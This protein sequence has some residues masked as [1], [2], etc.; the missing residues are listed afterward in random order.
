MRH[1]IVIAALLVLGCGDTSGGLDASE[2][3]TDGGIGPV[4]DAATGIDGGASDDAGRPPD[5]ATMADA[6]TVATSDPSGPGPYEVMRSTASLGDSSVA[7]FDPALPSGE[8]GPLVVFLH[9]FQLS[10]ANYVTTLERIATHGYV[11]VGLDSG[12][13]I[14][15]GP[16]QAEQAAQMSAAIDWALGAPVADRVDADRIAVMGHSRGGKVAVMVAAQDARVG[17]LLALDPV[18]SCGP[19]TPYSADC[20][21]VTTG[22]W[23]P[24]LAMPV[25]YMGETLDGSGGFMPCAPEAQSYATIYDASTAASPA[26]EWT[27]TNAAHMTFTDD[28]GGFAGSLCASATGDEAAM[29]EAIRTIAVAFLD[30][31]LRG[32]ASRDAWL[33]G[34]LPADVVLRQR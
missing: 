3:R 26:L 24:S 28:G 4:I 18:N 9:G 15:G 11:V 1:A 17:A 22:D 23:A 16:T 5:A 32:D 19:G 25:G 29:R 2:P 33:V 27:F 21:D 13:S 34:D 6:G 20:P 14:L 12:G 8:R 7:V 30:R 31:H 10:T